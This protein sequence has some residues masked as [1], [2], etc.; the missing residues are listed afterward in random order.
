MSP[1]NY[2]VEGRKC[3]VD[4]FEFDRREKDNSMKGTNVMCTFQFSRSAEVHEVRLR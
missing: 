4:W 2:V 1:R 3:E